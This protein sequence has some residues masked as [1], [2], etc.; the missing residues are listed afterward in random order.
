MNNLTI[1]K[2]TN[3][4]EERAKSCEANAI[5][6]LLEATDH[7]SNAHLSVTKAIT[8]TARNETSLA[9]IYRFKSHISSYTAEIALYNNKIHK[10][11]AMHYRFE[12]QLKT[13]DLQLKAVLF[14]NM[15][16]NYANE[17]KLHK[18][19]SQLFESRFKTYDA[20]GLVSKDYVNTCHS[21]DDTE[22]VEYHPN[23]AK[24][25]DNASRDKNLFIRSLNNAKD[26]LESAASC[27]KEA[28]YIRKSVSEA[29]KSAAYAA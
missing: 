26:C 20:L 14:E 18:A 11:H 3:H 6:C 15:A 2:R 25:W 29:R 10:C 22:A 23:A 28:N 24:A 21:M 13:N 12:A 17:A 4:Y 1:S 19:C 27:F 9:E 5:M 8:F 16:L 7:A